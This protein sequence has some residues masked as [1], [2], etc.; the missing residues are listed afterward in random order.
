[1]AGNEQFEFSEPEDWYDEDVDDIQATVA[2]YKVI[3]QLIHNGFSVDL[4]DFENDPP[5]AFKEIEVDLIQVSQSSF[6]FFENYRF[7]FR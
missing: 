2:V 3:Q 7:T 4:I 1:M 6:R 5:E